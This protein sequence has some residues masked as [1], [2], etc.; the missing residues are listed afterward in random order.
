[1]IDEF[2]QDD[3]ERTIK[4]SPV[5]EAH[6]PPDVNGARNA[7]PTRANTPRVEPT[8]S[9]P[10]AYFPRTPAVPPPPQPLMRESAARQRMRRRRVQGRRPGGEWAWVVIAAALLAVGLVSSMSVYLLLRVS[11]VEQEVMSTSVADL[12]QLPTAVSFRTEPG[13]FVTG[14]SLI[15]D[16]GRSLILEPWDGESRLTVLFMGLDRRPGETGLAYRSDTMILLS[17]DPRT[18]KLGILS[19]PRDLYVDVPGYS[20]LQRINSALV[21]AELNR[22][23]TGPLLAMQTVQYNLGMRV[24]EYVIMDFDAVVAL[25]NAIGGITIHNE[26]TINDRLYPDMNFGY[27]PFYL[28]T[29][30][31][32]LD[33][34]DALRFART[35]HGDNDFE[36]ARRQQQVLFAVRERVLDFNQLPNLIIQAPTLLSALSENVHTS[37]DLHQMIE[38]AWYLKDV[39]SDNF[40]TG[41]IDANYIMGYNTPQGAS[42]LVPNRHRMGTLLAEVFGPNYSE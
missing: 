18:Q 2:D 19:I 42:V 16:D 30:T 3:P 4:A 35:R 7:V 9:S 10:V 20:Q 33:G 40:V 22:P 41:V 36:R 15:L 26:R 32:H 11:Q 23:G 25:V 6:R 14:Q 27:D 5:P 39:P 1:M 31:H 8:I 13:E 12:S 37:L 29:G 34:R 38:L 17:L 21:L 24:H 28:P